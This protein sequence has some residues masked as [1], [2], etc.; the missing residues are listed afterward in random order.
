MTLDGACIPHP[1]PGPLPLMCG[2]I[3]E[4]DTMDMVVESGVGGAVDDLWVGCDDGVG[5]RVAFG[6]L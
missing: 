4:V 3:D 5:V 6:A 2:G 1:I